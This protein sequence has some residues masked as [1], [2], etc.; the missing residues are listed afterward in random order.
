MTPNERVAKKTG[1][2]QVY[3]VALIGNRVSVLASLTAIITD[4]IIPG[5]S[6]GALDSREGMPCPILFQGDHGPIEFR[7]IVIASRSTD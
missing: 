2:W 5:I 6:E 7:N 4:Q 1:E 3:D